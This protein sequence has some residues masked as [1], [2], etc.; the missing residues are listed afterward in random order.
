MITIYHNPRCR[1]SREALEAVTESGQEHQVRLYLQDV[2][3]EVE[4]KQLLKDLNMTAEE[5]IRKGEAIWKS[6]Y[7]GKDLTEDE[8][9]Q[10]MLE[11]PKLMERPVLTTANTAVVGR[12]I[13]NVYGL[14]EKNK[15][16]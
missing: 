9:V 6:D 4:L 12:P 10:A 8:L 7:K 15:Q 11:H 14:L 16:H 3:S 5:L 1:K 13:E 2:L